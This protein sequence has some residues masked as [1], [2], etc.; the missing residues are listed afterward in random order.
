MKVCLL[1]TPEEFLMKTYWT[2][3]MARRPVAYKRPL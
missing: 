3:A 1:F 2:I